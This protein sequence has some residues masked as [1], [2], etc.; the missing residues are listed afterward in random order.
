MFG[1]IIS[2]GLCQEKLCCQFLSITHQLMFTS[3]LLSYFIFFLFCILCLC[4]DT[5]QLVSW[6]RGHEGGVSSISVHSSGRYAI[7]TSS[8]T[9]QLWDMDTFQ[10]KRKLNIKQSVGIQKVKIQMCCLSHLQFKKG[11]KKLGLQYK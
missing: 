2:P 5:K 3:T 11:K 9:A 10:R 7:T 6:M 4:T 8:D 1:N